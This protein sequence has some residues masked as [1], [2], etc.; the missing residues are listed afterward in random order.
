MLLPRPLLC[1][2]LAASA[3]LPLLAGVSSEPRSA[4]ARVNGVPVT[5][6]E[7]D[8]EIDR[9]APSSVTA[10]GKSADN[11]ALRKKALDE[12]IVRELAYQRAKQLKLTVPAAEMNATVAKIRGRYKSSGSF[13]KALAAEQI[14]EQEFRQRVE[15]DLLLRKIYKREVD[16]KAVITRREADAYYREQKARFLEPESL[17][18]LQVFVRESKTGQ[19]KADEALSKL[20]SGTP[21]FD[22]AYTYSEDD[23]RVVGG[24]YGWVHL[25]QLSP[26]VE[27]LVF[28]APPKKL[29]G[30]VHTSFGWHIVEVREH[31]PARQLTLEEARPTINDSLHR[32]RLARVREEFSNRL[33]ENAR[34]EYVAP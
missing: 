5:S 4:V 34:I 15:K 6:G 2:L 8:A 1:P 16:D 24:D 13:N 25:G 31:R 33:R 12:L 26:E 3:V 27:K 20:K 19:S 28:S 14:S 21:F 22:V 29:V 17:W 7:L 30:P 32:A 18:L 11:A 9:L 10:H 23:Y